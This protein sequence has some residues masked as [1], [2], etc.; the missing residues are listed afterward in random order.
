MAVITL[1]VYS[2]QRQHNRLFEVRTEYTFVSPNLDGAFN[3]FRANEWVPGPDFNM[4]T[5]TLTYLDNWNIFEAAKTDP[6]PSQG[7]HHFGK[8]LEPSDY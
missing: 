2:V 4:L 8:F 7:L 6:W 5:W 1:F 3:V